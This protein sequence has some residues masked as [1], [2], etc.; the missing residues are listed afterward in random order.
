MDVAYWHEYGFGSN[1][2]R[3]F[4]RV[5]FKAK[6]AAIAQALNKSFRMVFEEGEDAESQ[7]EKVGVFLQNI[8]KRSWDNNGYGT[9][10]VLKASTIRAKTVNGKAGNQ[11]LFDTGIL[12]GSITYEVRNAA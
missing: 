6:D 2:Q 4:L 11:T 3:S 1:P 9:W 7:L 10:P 12:L 8:S 5:P